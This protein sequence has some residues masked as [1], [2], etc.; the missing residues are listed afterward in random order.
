MIIL[1]L[2]WCSLLN[3]RVTAV[4][5]VLAIALSVTLMLGVEK[6]RM[7]T[8]NGFLNTISGTDLIIGARAS[9]VQLL[10]YAVF[11]IGDA[12][13]N[14]TWQTV[15]DI[16]ARPEVAWLVPISL[17]DN[18]KGFRVM[19]TT[20]GYFDHYK[21]RRQQPLEFA[22]GSRFDD[23][24]D[25]VLGHQ[26]AATLG[27]RLGSKIVVTHGAGQVS[28]GND[29]ADKPFWVVGILQPTGTPVDRT[30]HVSMQAIE[31]IHV[32]WESGAAPRAGNQTS[33]EAVRLLD[34]QP[35]S[36]TALYVGLKSRMLA[37]SLQRWINNYPEEAISAVL[38]GVAFG[39]LWRILGNLET[40]L[41]VISAMV[42]FTAILGM[43][44]SVLGSLNERRR[45]MA[46]LRSIGARPAHIFGLL[47]TEAVVLVAVGTA[48]GTATVYTLL[49][50]GQSATEEA[51]GLYLHLNVMTA[52]EVYLL[53]YIMIGGLIAAVFPAMRAYYLSL[54]DGLVIRT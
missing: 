26:V 45:E 12:T 33:A 31:A 9:P 1:R 17:G 6:V 40:A 34:L 44:I 41:L 5:T 51:T 38:P 22:E 8:K 24:Y 4:L 49:W 37:F 10:L 39:Q 54:S 53:M 32:G 19:G 52:N 20:R 30:V 36:A 28:F 3:R 43:V 13:A 25:A 14:I 2:A 35:R 29:H 50:A 21:Y 42:V 27:Y 48:L 16:K 11:R 47:L 46:I 7:G 15:T 18:H 23:L